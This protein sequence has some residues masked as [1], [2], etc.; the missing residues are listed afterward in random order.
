M[1]TF[2]TDSEDFR[3]FIDWLIK[4]EIIRDSWEHI[5]QVFTFPEK[6]YEEYMQFQKGPTRR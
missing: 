3:Q 4:K 6:F 1:T 5:R 2:R